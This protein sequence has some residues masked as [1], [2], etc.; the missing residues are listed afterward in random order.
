MQTF[1]PY[2]DFRE[3]AH[4]LDNKRLGK[5]RVETLQVLKALTI[6]KY[7]WKSHPAVKMWKNYEYRLAD[8]GLAICQEWIDRGYKDTCYDKIK[9]IRDLLPLQPTQPWWLGDEALHASHRSNLLRKDPEFYNQWSWSESP[10]LPYVW[11]V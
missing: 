2:K 1:L 4:A 6:E 5:Q 8:Y 9:A 10:D 7:G 11:P 3:S